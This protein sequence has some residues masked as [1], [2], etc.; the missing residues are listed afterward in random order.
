MIKNCKIVKFSDD[1]F[2]IESLLIGKYQIEKESYSA[3]FT[4][5]SDSFYLILFDEKKFPNPIEKVLKNLQSLKINSLVIAS[6]ISYENAM[7]L[8]EITPDVIFMPVTSKFIQNKIENIASNILPEKLNLPKRII[9]NQFFN[10][11]QLQKIFLKLYKADPLLKERVLNISE[12]SKDKTILEKMVAEAETALNNGYFHMYFQPVVNIKE[13]KLSGF[14]SLIRWIDPE[15]GMIPPDDFI[16]VLEGS[17]FIFKLTYWIIEDVIK[18]IAELNKIGFSDK[19][20]NVNICAKHFHLEELAET[21]EK[22]RETYAITAG[23]LGIEITESAF[24][25]DMKIANM[26]L[27][28][29][30]SMNYPLYMDDFGTGYSSLSYLQHFPV[31]IIKIDKSFVTWMHVDEQSEMIVKSIIALAH[32]L[33]M[34]VVAE[35][36]EDEEHVQLLNNF[37]CEYGQG[38]FYSK[39]LDKKGAMLFINEFGS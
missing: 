25:E 17:D 21:I 4:P 7:I 34:K 16:P 38:Y 8:N 13:N 36:V 31:E 15:K 29:L 28:K 20:I 37:G 39:P 2:Q 18:F 22:L 10:I 30:K 35:G 5:E 6:V 9:S 14:E 32:G 3:S 19:R 23:Q 27:L 24:M 1:D 26:N 11:R 12:N 33:N